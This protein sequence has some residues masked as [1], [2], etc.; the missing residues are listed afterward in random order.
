MSKV[1]TEYKG[2]KLSRAGQYIH[3]KIEDTEMGAMLRGW[4]FNN[5]D[6]AR[7]T[8]DRIIGKYFE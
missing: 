8:I 2:V 1:I 4:Y 5:T 6:E 3:A 7:S